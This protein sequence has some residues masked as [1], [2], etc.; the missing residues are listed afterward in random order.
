MDQDD[1]VCLCPGRNSPYICRACEVREKFE[2][3]DERVEEFCGNCDS[4]TKNVLG[5]DEICEECMCLYQE[6]NVREA[7]L[8]ELRE[9]EKWPDTIDTVLFSL[10]E[11][12]KETDNW[13]PGTHDFPCIIESIAQKDNLDCHKKIQY[14]RTSLWW[15][16]TAEL[17]KE[18][19]NGRK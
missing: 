10:T 19:T 5:E 6:K 3:M 4:L 1:Y 2:A 17:M 7:I 8:A 18:V 13:S 15:K 11:M 9:M 12:L 16:R 14:S